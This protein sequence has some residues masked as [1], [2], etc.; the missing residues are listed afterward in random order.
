MSENI[1][2]IIE[3]IENYEDGNFPKEDLQILI[4]NKEEATPYL[5][6]SIRNP[7]ECVEKLLENED[8]ILPY[9]A[10]YLLAQFREKEAYPLIYDLF[11]YE[12]EKTDKVWGD[13][14]T[15]DLG[16]ILASVCDG[17]VSLINKLIEDEDVYEYVRSSAMISWVCLLKAKKVTREQI[18]D[19]YRQLLQRDW[20]EYSLLCAA[21]ICNC[22]DIKALELMPEMK[23]CFEKEQVDEGV[24]GDW[25]SVETDIKDDDYYSYYEENNEYDLVDDMISDLKTW[26]Y[27]KSEEER[28]ESSKKL[29][30][31][32]TELLSEHQQ[33]KTENE[34]TLEKEQIAWNS[35]REGT[36][37]REI[38]K[39]GNNESCPCE[40]GLKYKKCCMNS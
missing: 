4:D 28:A 27:F 5:L 17:D 37:I 13:L 23:E 38:P 1:K 16:Q 35:N 33:L 8:Y 6:D 2:E 20:E 25:E 19:Y 32:F 30:K 3:K 9:Y 34:S 39:V 24:T 36:F 18:I 29:N 10:L 21:L 12:A 15:T 26:H 31:M 40:S 7:A 22:V 11:S 14:I